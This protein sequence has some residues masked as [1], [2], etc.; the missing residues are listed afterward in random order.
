MTQHENAPL[1]PKES[2]QGMIKVIESLEMEDT[3]KFLSWEGEPIP[4]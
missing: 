3:G 2:I 4:W 1:D